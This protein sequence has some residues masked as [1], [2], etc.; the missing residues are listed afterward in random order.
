M[1]NTHNL[2]IILQLKYMLIVMNPAR[3]ASSY[4]KSYKCYGLWYALSSKRVR[5]APMFFTFLILSFS[6]CSQSFNKICVWEV[7]GANVLKSFTCLFHLIELS[8]R[9]KLALLSKI[10]SSREI[11]STQKF[12]CWSYFGLKDLHEFI[13]AGGTIYRKQVCFK[14]QNVTVG[15][16][17]TK[18][19]SCALYCYLNSIK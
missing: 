8:W 5:W 10:T 11:R 9:G 7:L 1:L 18:Y 14:I 15:K 4:W 12:C 13:F 2:H 3:I 17:A 6:T 16:D 19:K